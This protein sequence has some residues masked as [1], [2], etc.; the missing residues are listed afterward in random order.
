M[1]HPASASDLAISQGIWQQHLDLLSAAMPGI[2]LLLLLQ[3]PAQ[4][5]L[6]LAPV[7]QVIFDASAVSSGVGCGPVG[8]LCM[9]MLHAGD[10]IVLAWSNHCTRSWITHI[11]EFCWMSAG[12]HVVM[13]GWDVPAFNKLSAVQSLQHCPHTWNHLRL[14]PQPEICGL[15]VRAHAPLAMCLW[16]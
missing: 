14:L 1:D 5:D 12:C 4:H 6:A 7:S 15:G 10:V 13:A 9:H 2:I 16:C 11:P 3:L 8:C